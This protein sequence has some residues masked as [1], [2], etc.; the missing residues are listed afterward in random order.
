MV[1]AAL[2]SSG[3]APQH[4]DLQPPSVPKKRE[5]WSRAGEMITLVAYLGISILA[6][7]ASPV[8]FSVGL[9]GAIISAMVINTT[10]GLLAKNPALLEG[11][12]GPLVGD[13]ISAACLA[14]TLFGGTTLAFRATRTAL[15]PTLVSTLVGYCVPLA[16]YHEVK[17][18]VSSG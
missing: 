12:L 3:H 16:L 6:C 5:L 11:Y 9:G 18:L 15:L 17:A 14:I 13:M 10:I 2:F 8:A 7:M 1:L 4:F